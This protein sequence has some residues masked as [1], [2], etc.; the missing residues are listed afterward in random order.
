[1]QNRMFRA[2]GLE[3]VFEY[4]YRAFYDEK[5]DFA[6]GLKKIKPLGIYRHAV[7]KRNSDGELV[8]VEAEHV[9]REGFDMTL[10]REED[11]MYTHSVYEIQTED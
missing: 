3:S 10:I 11:G 6:E 4:N 2:A 5:T 8:S 9:N 7:V 1:L